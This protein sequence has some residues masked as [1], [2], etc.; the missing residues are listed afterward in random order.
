MGTFSALLA[1]S[2]GNS[3]V[4]GEFPSQR[5]VTRS[6]DVSFHLRL[7]KRLRK[8]PW[9]WWFGTP[10]CPL[11]RHSNGGMIGQWNHWRITP[12]QTN[13]IPFY[14]QTIS[15][16]LAQ[17]CHQKRPMI[18]HFADVVSSGPGDVALWRHAY[19][20]VAFT[21]CFQIPRDSGKLVTV[22]WFMLKRVIRCFM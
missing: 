9:G 14:H 8:Q 4:T 10:S 19:C 11:W 18:L 12:W 7:N 5:P 22:K 21:D 3:S 20:Y 17:E 6:F 15:S 2:V 1:L 16:S 13:R